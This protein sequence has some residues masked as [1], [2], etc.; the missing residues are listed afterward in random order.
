MNHDADPRH[1]LVRAL[2]EQSPLYV[3][4]TEIHPDVPDFTCNVRGDDP[5][6]GVPEDL[7]RSLASWAM[8]RPA[9]GFASRPELR[10]HVKEGREKAQLL[11]AHL[12]PAWVVRYWDEQHES[13]KFVCW[14]CRRLHWTLGAH[15]DP[16]HPL[17]VIVQG[18]YRWYPLRAE[19]FEDFAPD[20]PA[21]ALGLSDSLVDDLYKWSA[22]VDA[23]MDLYLQEREEDEREAR[24]EE[25]ERRGEALA[26]RVVQEVGPGRTVTYRGVW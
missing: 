12:G 14:G 10:K 16:P 2:G 9:A 25:L 23:N 7:V 22:D 15:G 4:E 3:P 5:A 24:K 18:E 11:A 13:A 19:G 6:L 21:A 8:S 26:A 1:L 17:H 20:D